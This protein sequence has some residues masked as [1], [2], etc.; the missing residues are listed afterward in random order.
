MRPPTSSCDERHCRLQGASEDRDGVRA[1]AR[2][3]EGSYTS[4]RTSKPGDL[5]T[6][7]PF[8]S[9]P[10]RVGHGC[11]R[12]SW[13]AAGERQLHPSHWEECNMKARTL[14]PLA[15][16]ESALTMLVAA[17]MASATHPRPVGAS[18]IRVS[19]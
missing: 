2:C 17:E 4:A 7:S 13:T 3:G 5:F 18:P 12:R 15:L 6:D 14:V 8:R 1:R 10:D 9:A 19:M 16:A 11:R